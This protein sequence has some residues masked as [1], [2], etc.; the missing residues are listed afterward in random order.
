MVSSSVDTD[1]PVLRAKREQESRAA[2]AAV[3]TTDHFHSLG[4]P[5]AP[6]AACDAAAVG[7]FAIASAAMK[8]QS[9]TASTDVREPYVTEE[10]YVSNISAGSVGGRIS[11]S[12]MAGSYTGSSYTASSYA[13]RREE[14]A[15]QVDYHKQSLEQ[16]N[17][18][19]ILFQ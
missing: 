16:G 6:D 17:H 19:H 14:I 13:I 8:R 18:S 10:P 5:A 12:A 1:S 2:S 7:G 3:G 9:C 15:K 4:S 11:T